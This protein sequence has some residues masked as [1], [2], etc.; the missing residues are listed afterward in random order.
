[1]F[2]FEEL[3]EDT[4]RWMREEFERDMAAGT[5]Y[6]STRFSPTGQ[7][8]Y[9]ALLRA[10]IEGGN[11]R[12]LT[13]AL[14]LPQFWK[15]HEQRVRQGKASLARVNPGN[16]ARVMAEGEFNVFYMRG[17]CRKLLE[18]G[19]T[20]VEAYRARAAENPRTGERVNPGDILPCQ[21]VL[22]DLRSRTD[23]ESKIGVPR[24]P[25]SGI[26]LRWKR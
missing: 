26:S 24:G 15:S 16:A 8:A 14:S 22:D 7:A 9:P 1:M 20:T 23:G 11:E 13:E 12:T 10:A 21:D 3:D 4:R 6:L 5:L 2:Q 25:V 18:Q 19:Q 17:L